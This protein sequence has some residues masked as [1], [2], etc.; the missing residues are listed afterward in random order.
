MRT[1][2]LSKLPPERRV[3]RISESLTTTVYD[4]DRVEV[5]DLD[6][7]DVGSL[8][9]S[10]HYPSQPLQGRCGSA[11]FYS[12]S[13]LR[14]EPVRDKDRMLRLGKREPCPGEEHIPSDRQRCV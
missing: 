10:L 2:S 7:D 12:R 1:T 6:R 14:S 4:D 9:G 5:I 13:L 8:A 11:Y 3:S